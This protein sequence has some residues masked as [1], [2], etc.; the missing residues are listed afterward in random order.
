[1]A[2]V[3]SLVTLELSMTYLMYV[4]SLQDCLLILGLKSYS[5]IHKNAVP[6]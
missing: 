4:V 5:I 6:A 2:D 1:M 3:V